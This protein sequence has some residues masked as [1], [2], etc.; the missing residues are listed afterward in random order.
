MPFPES[1]AP[2][3]RI[4][5]SSNTRLLQIIGD[6]VLGTGMARD[7]LYENGPIDFRIMTRVAWSVVALLLVA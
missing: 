6:G 5:L 3:Y 1:S 4:A 7:G 2:V